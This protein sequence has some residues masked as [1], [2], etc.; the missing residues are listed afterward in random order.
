MTGSA[1]THFVQECPTCGRR[2][3]VRVSLLGRSICC[4]HCQAD[5]IASLHSEPGSQTSDLLARAEMLLGESG[6]AR[7]VDTAL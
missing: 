6:T 1:S 4:P 5:F 2:L 3:Q 7:T